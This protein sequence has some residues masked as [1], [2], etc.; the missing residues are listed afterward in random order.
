MNSEDKRV[1][2]VDQHVKM[3]IY[4]ESVDD[5]SLLCAR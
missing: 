4:D 2:L 1:D 5:A 3:L